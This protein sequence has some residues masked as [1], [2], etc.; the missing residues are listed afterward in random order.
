MAEAFWEL[1]KDPRWQRK[2]LEVMSLAGFAC[3]EC[4]DTGTTLNVHHGYYEKG[5]APWEYDNDTLHC[6]CEPCHK[7]TSELMS[8]VKP[9][10]ALCSRQ[11]I[12]S[13]ASYVAVRLAVRGKRRIRPGAAYE[14]IKEGLCDYLGLPDAPKESIGLMD[15]S[16][17][18]LQ[19]MRTVEMFRRR[20]ILNRLA[21][22]TLQGVL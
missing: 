8:L 1:Y 15:L 11:E 22:G 4:G 13:V 14:W 20:S 9:L 3:E 21:P 18:A 16:P 17:E 2:R 10:L 5:N 12:D 6:L 19:S 7:L